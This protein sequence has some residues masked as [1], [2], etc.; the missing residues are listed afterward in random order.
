MKY[1]KKFNEGVTPEEIKDIKKKSLLQKVKD[2]IKSFAQW[3]PHETDPESLGPPTEQEIERRKLSK[4]IEDGK[5]NPNDDISRFGPPTSDDIRRRRIYR[6][7]K[8][9][10]GPSMGDMGPM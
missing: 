2:K 8:N 3:F 4:E 10:K 1:L 9:S 7:I 5:W 6:D